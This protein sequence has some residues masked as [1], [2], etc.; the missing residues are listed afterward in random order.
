MADEKKKFLEETNSLLKQI[1]SSDQINTDS[2][3]SLD[4]GKSVSKF[5]S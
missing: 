3:E 4:I 1:G 2:K 5:F